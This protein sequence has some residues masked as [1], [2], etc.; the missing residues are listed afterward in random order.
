MLGWRDDRS[1]YACTVNPES[2]AVRSFANGS[3]PSS[4]VAR[5]RGKRLLLT[6]EF[7]DGLNLDCE[8]VKRITGGSPMTAR[9]MRENDSSFT[10]DGTLVM[11]ANVWPNVTDPTLFDGGR[12][13]CFPFEHH[14]EEGEIDQSLRGRLHDPRELSGLL[15]WCLDG[16]RAYRR[17]GLG[18][19]PDAVR[20]M[21][22]RFQ[23]ESDLDMAAVREFCEFHLDADATPGAYV[24]VKQIEV[25]FKRGHHTVASRRFSAI[26][27]RLYH[28]EP[29]PKIGD[30]QPRNAIRGYR[31]K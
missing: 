1:G 11:L 7:S 9:R 20:D 6:T 19:T 27:G 21:G 18:E 14:L 15:N 4:D 17:D 3:G 23:A 25:E 30:K 13:V 31:Y 22:N 24:T 2:L 29:R 8:L 26:V 28:V 5:W 12:P 16:L 10:M